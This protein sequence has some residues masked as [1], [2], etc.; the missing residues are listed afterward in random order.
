M[1][2][3]DEVLYRLIDEGGADG[4]TAADLHE[5]DETAVSVAR[6]RAN[7]G[8]GIKRRVVDG[9]ERF[10][11]HETHRPVS[12]ALPN[13]WA[14]NTHTQ[15]RAGRA[16]GHLPALDREKTMTHRE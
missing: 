11:L 15:S 4:L 3:F 1:D 9:R 12:S 13:Q 6:A 7:I 10:Y 2:V 14:S 8:D 5:I 16:G